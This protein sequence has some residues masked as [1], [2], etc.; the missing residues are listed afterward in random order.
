M[1]IPQAVLMLFLFLGFLVLL[2][3][4]SSQI[5]LIMPKGRLVRLVGFVCLQ[6]SLSLSLVYEYFTPG[7]VLA[8]VGVLFVVS[9]WGVVVLCKAVWASMHFASII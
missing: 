9:D 2:F 4:F 6:I 1:S 8:L 7:F 3:N 5:V